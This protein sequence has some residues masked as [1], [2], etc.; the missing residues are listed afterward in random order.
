MPLKLVAIGGLG[1]MLSPSA[2]HLQNHRDAHYLR[3]LDRGGNNPIKQQR[4]KAWQE[5]GAQLVSSIAELVDNQDFDGVVICAGKNGDDYGILK[6]LV[7]LLK[8]KQFILHLST[9]SCAFVSA[10]FKFCAQHKLRYANYPLTGGAKGAE[11][12]K[13]LILASGDKALYEQLT[14]MLIKIG[15]PQYFGEEVTQGAAVKLIGHVMV[16]HGLLG[17][18]LAAVLHK[19]VLGL[20]HLDSQ[21]VSFFDFLN[22]GAGGTKQWDV[23]L[24]AG[25][26]ENKWDQGFFV[27]HAVIDAL[28]AAS[29]LAE[30]NVPAT[31]ILPI[32]EVVL[33]FAYLLKK[34][35]LSSPA[36]Q[37]I[38]R[39][40]AE[41]PKTELDHYLQAH[42]SFDIQQCIKNCIQALPVDLQNSLMLDVGF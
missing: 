3:V 38:A 4:R 31:L 19:N 1:T 36:T 13:M 20:P 10:A 41:E 22:Q 30:K 33:L 15:V 8:A 7:P 24:R 16:F 6:E 18:S 37:T 14:P 27:H 39:L 34:N 23:T 2:T 21:Q 11:S 12:G 35:V 32:L 9:L 25:L 28:Y 42:L 17:I 40:I 29:L 5:Q 26:A